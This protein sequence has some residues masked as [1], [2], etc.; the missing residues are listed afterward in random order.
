MTS[1]DHVLRA[2]AEP[3]RRAILRLVADDELPVGRLAEQ[4][5]VTRS[6]ISQHLR[7]L[8]DAGLVTHRG[9]GTRNYYRAVPDGLAALRAYLDETWAAALDTGRRLVEI[10]AGVLREDGSEDDERALA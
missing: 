8:E 10:D 4:F 3:R 1:T 6:A 7:V 5:E 2:L 9:E